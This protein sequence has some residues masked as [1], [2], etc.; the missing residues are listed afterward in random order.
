MGRHRPPPQQMTHRGQPRC[1]AMS[2]QDSRSP[3]GV[4]VAGACD[5]APARRRRSAACARRASPGAGGL[6]CSASHRTSCAAGHNPA[7][8]ATSR[9]S[10]LNRRR[11]CSWYAARNAAEASTGGRVARP[12]L[13]NTELAAPANAASGC[14]PA[15]VV[16]CFYDDVPPASQPQ[17]EH[18]GYPPRREQHPSRFGSEPLGASARQFLRCHGGDSS[19]L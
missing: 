9:S 16:T 19:L 18:R 5:H 10:G 13:G 8:H 15:V 17:S 3:G 4:D 6:P 14:G 11:R 2:D 7:A 12:V 1:L